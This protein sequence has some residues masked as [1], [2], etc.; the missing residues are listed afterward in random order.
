MNYNSHAGFGT[1]NTFGQNPQPQANPM[2]G[3]L[4]NPT[5]TN[6]GFGTCLLGLSMVTVRVSRS[7]QRC[8]WRRYIRKYRESTFRGNQ[9]CDR[10][11]SIRRRYRYVD[12]WRRRDVWRG[13]KQCCRFV[14]CL[15]SACR[16]LWVWC[17]HWIEFVRQTSHDGFWECTE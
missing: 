3:N 13:D 11:W 7:F 4:S 9:A 5:S 8:F 6:S 17:Q 15:W 2:F 12:V 10:F 16:Y 1:G 14:R